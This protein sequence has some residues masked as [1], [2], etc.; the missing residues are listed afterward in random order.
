MNTIFSEIFITES[1]QRVFMILSSFAAAHFILTD[2]V[3]RP[4]LVSLLG[5]ESRFQLMFSGVV[6]SLFAAGRSVYHNETFGKGDFIPFLK[7]NEEVCHILGLVLTSLAGVLTQWVGTRFPMDVEENKPV[8]G[9]TRLVRHPAETASFLSFSGNI[10]LRQRYSDL[11]AFLPLLFLAVFGSMH[12]DSR[13]RYENPLR[14]HFDETTWLP[15]GTLISG[16]Q[17]FLK[18]IKEIGFKRICLCFLFAALN[19]WIVTSGYGSYII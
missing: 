4:M 16:K 10:L 8:T 7:E 14:K 11:Y 12:Q 3:V 17:S 5:T 18:A 9:I 19:I 13:V 2:K 6:L 15:F 1:N